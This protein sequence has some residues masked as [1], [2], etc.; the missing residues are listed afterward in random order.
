M[1]EKWRIQLPLYNRVLELIVR[2]KQ[3]DALRTVWSMRTALSVSANITSYYFLA[4]ALLPTSRSWPALQPRVTELLN[5]QPPGHRLNLYQSTGEWTVRAAV[6]WAVKAAELGWDRGGGGGG[7]GL[8][9]VVGLER[10]GE[11][12]SVLD[13]LGL[14]CE[15]GVGNEVLVSEEVLERW[16]RNRRLAAANAMRSRVNG[17]RSKSKV[18]AG[19]QQ[20]QASLS[21]AQMVVIRA[22]IRLSWSMLTIRRCLRW[23][24]CNCGKQQHNSK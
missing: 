13:E 18:A 9:V 23:R 19:Q 1:N 10:R 22:W 20:Q 4:Q 5:W 2:Q 8:G 7:G 14:S 17:N 11:V 6:W 21:M 12:V 3:W 16:K 24:L 15:V